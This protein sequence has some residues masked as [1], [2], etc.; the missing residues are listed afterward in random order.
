[1]LSM[2][3]GIPTPVD[4]D[5]CRRFCRLNDLEIRAVAINALNHPIFNSPRMYWPGVAGAACMAGFGYVRSTQSEPNLQA[6]L[7]NYF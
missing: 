1:M 7:K 5:R 2:A 4:S 3:K 6:G